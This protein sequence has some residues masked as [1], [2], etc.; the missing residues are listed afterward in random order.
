MKIDRLIGI[1]SLLLQREKVTAKELS[2]KF[3]V[4][5]RTVLRDIDSLNMAGIPVASSIGK[6]GGFYIMEGYKIDKTLLSS[7]DMQLIFAGLKGLDSVSGSNRYRRLM[8]KLKVESLATSDNIIIDLS[9]WDK[10]VVSE[11]IEIINKAVSE[12]AKISFTYHSPNGESQR[13]IEPYRLIFQW[14]GWYVWG[15]CL[16]RNDYRMFKLTRLT[17]L[18]IS[19][20][21][22]EKR[23][24]PP[25]VSDKL[26][27]TEGEIEATARFDKSVKWRIIDEFGTELPKFDTEGNST[28]TFT[29]SDVPSFYRYILSFGDDA[30][31]LNPKEYREEFK[32]LL[33]NI[34]NKYKGENL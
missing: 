7:E 8:D 22:C 25:F 6:G 21:K 24:I 1:L 2:E 5:Y 32:E 27:H 12:N 28:L 34:Q 14:A 33:N 17:D 19:E 11:K 26:R 3:E 10:S 18:K 30:E 4:S 15:Y 23:D 13:I 16:K 31:I 29:W 20:E 9:Y